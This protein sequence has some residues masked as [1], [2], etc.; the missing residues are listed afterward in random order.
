MTAVSSL[1]DQWME[2]HG[3]PR[4]FESGVMSGFDATQYEL[5]GFGV[6]VRRKGN[7]FAVRRLD[8]R[9]QVMRW[10]KLVE[11]RDD[12]RRLHGREPLRRIGP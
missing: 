5:Q 4:R 1:V 12:F 10:E 7:R 9:W 6:E 2:S 3:G 8:G 11:L